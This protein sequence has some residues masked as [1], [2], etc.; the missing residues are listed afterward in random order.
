MSAG[1]ADWP[2][3]NLGGGASYSLGTLIRRVRSSYNFWHFGSWER[4]SPYASFGAFFA[5]W[6]G[7][8]GVVVNYA[9]TISEKVGGKL[10]SLLFAAALQ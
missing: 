4:Y 1:P 10:D 7:T 3:A 9:P 5:L 8:V 6:G 2:K